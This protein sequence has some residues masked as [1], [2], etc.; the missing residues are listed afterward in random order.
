MVFSL[1][2]LFFSTT[3]A[4]L[5]AQTVPAQV[6][7]A[8]L[9]FSNDT[10]EQLLAKLADW[11]QLARYRADNALLPPP[12]A[13]EKRVV[14]FGSST[15]DNWGRKYGSVFFPGKPYL[16]RGISGQTT[17]QMLIRFQQDVVA[18]HPAAVVILAGSNDIAGNTGLTT[19]NDIEDNFRSIMAIAQANKI[20]VILAS[21]LPTISYS[22]NKLMRPESELLAL[23]AWEKQYAA[24]TGSAYVNYY[25]ALV[26]DNGSF[27]PG[28]SVDGL[29][30][31]AEGYA[32]MGPVIQQ[33]LDDV[34]QQP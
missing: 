11:P 18:L 5:P 28:L 1:M 19:L 16:N 9:P 7:P 14:F 32:I 23:S 12:A 15:T 21:Q 4:N 6:A 22:W 30:P 34:L 24:E 31:T 2:F 25:A 27:R 8:A 20:K 33:V 3:A 13:G 29:H 26:G 10:P 17:P